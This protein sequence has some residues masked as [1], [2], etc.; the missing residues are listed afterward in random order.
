M[1][2]NKKNKSQFFFKPGNTKPMV[3]KFL[4][5]SKQINV[6]LSSDWSKSL[7]S[8]LSQIPETFQFLKS[9]NESQWALSVNN[10]IIEKD[11]P[12]TFG[13]I[14]STL[15][16]TPIIEI[17]SINNQP[18]NKHHMGVHTII[19]HY[20]KKRFNYSIINN[21]NDWNNFTYLQLK[22]A[23]KKQFNVNTSFN[24]Y[25]NTKTNKVY[26]ND[27][28]DV[29]SACD[30]NDEIH[31]FVETLEPEYKN[32]NNID[33][34]ANQETERMLSS[35]NEYEL[36]D[37]KETLDDNKSIRSN[38]SLLARMQNKQKVISPIHDKQFDNFQMSWNHVS[39]CVAHEMWPKL[40]SA[41]KGIVN[42]ADETQHP[43]IDA[44]D[45][46]DKNTDNIINILK[47]ERQLAIEEREY[48]KKL[49]KR[50][51]EFSPNIPLQNNI[52]MFN[53]DKPLVSIDFDI[54]RKGINAS[55]L[56]DIF[57]VQRV[58][59]FENFHFREYNV[60]DF[61]NDINEYGN[62]YLGSKFV[63][64]HIKQIDFYERYNLYPAYLIED[65]IFSIFHYNFGISYY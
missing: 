50:A 55:L 32:S 4:L 19:V 58:F 36:N 59:I 12:N 34:D 15:S 14:M 46:S 45:L 27:I 49:V 63:E 9:V 61:R 5:Q 54:K 40:A 38:H 33:L 31:F 2:S 3:L 42:N 17:V 56:M 7:K 6:S 48:L 60:R 39:Q 47:S 53:I 1:L 51:R 24:L 62:K 52:H 25:Q 57:D 41:I 28:N 35:F 44:Y 18:Q 10:T 43:M 37:L 64:Q 8:I 65:D 21:T 29:K 16:T 13:K 30:Q 23:V 20:N 26:V 11:D 22:E